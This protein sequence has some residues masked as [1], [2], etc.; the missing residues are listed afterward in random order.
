MSIHNIALAVLKVNFYSKAYI[1]TDYKN[2]YTIMGT[3]K[4]V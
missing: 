3:L 1:R 4:M 2:E